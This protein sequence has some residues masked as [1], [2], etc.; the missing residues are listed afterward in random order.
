MRLKNKIDKL[1]VVMKKTHLIA[2]TLAISVLFVILFY[3]KMIGINLLLFE[4]AVIPIMFYVNRPVKF[5]FLTSSILFTTGLTAVFAV[6]IS[7]SW[8]IFINFVL[9]FCLGY[10][11]AFQ[12]GKSFSHV[13][14]GAFLRCFLAQISFFTSHPEDQATANLPS[15][16]MKKAYK[17]F[18]FVV[19]PVCILLFFFFLYTSS[20]SI[21]SQSVQP[22]LNTMADMLS[23]IN[24]SL[25]FFFILG[26]I[27]VNPLLMRIKPLSIYEHDLSSYNDLKRIRK[28]QYFSFRANALQT[29]N[30]TGIV[31]LFMLNALI[32]CFNY[33]DITNIWIGFEWDGTF[34]KEFVH[35]G[36]W[37]LLFSVCI[38]AIIA[39][40]FFHSNLNFYSKNKLLKRLT[41]LWIAQNFIMTVSVAIRNLYYINYF[42]LAY[43]R[44]A[45]LFFLALV[46]VGLITI[47]I[48]ILKIKSSYFL[49]R[50]NGF[51]LLAVLT[52]SSLF[53]W[54][55]IITKYNFAHYNRSLI[56]YRFIC[57]LSNASL[58]Y[59]I[60]TLE[61]LS[62]IDAVQRKTMPFDISQ[63]HLW[64][65]EKYYENIYKK[66][67][68]FLNTYK[69]RSILEWNLPDYSAYKKLSYN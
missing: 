41:V 19:I 20:S 62:D 14:C 26:I 56:E 54:D 59:A 39:L 27:V 17:F 58:P 28:K 44:I 31:L 35:E 67:D 69:S 66:K 24:F 9:L 46:A 47:I 11:L 23:N 50:I 65:Y 48:K 33:V 64:S 51:S 63:D 18:F 36:T 6:I 13:V 68:N 22:F 38:S 32:L 4:V 16:A 25:L 53:N 1:F 5:N 55:V 30:T 2:L 61:Q 3:Q 10:V 7:T 8:G 29:Q 37:I 43:K 34:L 12:K 57:E 42:G 52:V 60:K 40:Y 21:F 15:S 45:V 49:W